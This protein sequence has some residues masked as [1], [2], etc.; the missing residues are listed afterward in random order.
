ML[1]APRLIA[2]PSMI[3]SE[4]A[5][6]FL[7]SSQP[8]TRAVV[9]GTPQNWPMLPHNP[10][11]AS[12]TESMSLITRTYHPLIELSIYSESSDPSSRL[13]N[14]GAGWTMEDYRT[15]KLL[16]KGQQL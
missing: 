7:E 9:G 10:T 5:G 1:T 12:R 3:S 13:R 6:S 16:I 4:F 8:Y 2:R 11:K 15:T 14:P